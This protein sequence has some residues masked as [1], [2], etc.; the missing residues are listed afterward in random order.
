MSLYDVEREQADGQI[1]TLARSRGQ[2]L[3]LVNVASRCG[4]TPQYE[5]LQQ[6]QQRFGERGFSVLAFP[7]N[8]FGGQEPGTNAEIQSFCSSH[9]AVTFPVFAKLEVN[10][11]G[12]HP[13]YR[14]LKAAAPGV[15]GSEA[16]KWNFTKFLISAEGEVVD[17]FAPT[18]TPE[19]LAER[20]EA[21]LKA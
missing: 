7:C 10:G 15:L 3:L 20:I 5:G 8:Q 12:A 4:F 21:L 6:L 2:V 1:T 14:Q 19:S 11:D 13:L 18:T 16:I 17:R 9:F